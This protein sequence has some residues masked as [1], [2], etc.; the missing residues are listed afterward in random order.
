MS[1]I[2]TNTIFHKDFIDDKDDYKVEDFESLSAPFYF[3]EK[4]NPDP[5]NQLLAGLLGD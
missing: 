3:L 5:Q 4:P 2:N 1:F